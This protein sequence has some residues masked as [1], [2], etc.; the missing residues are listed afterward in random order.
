LPRCRHT[1]RAVRQNGHRTPT[2]SL[3][4]IIELVEASRRPSRTP[5]TP[6]PASPQTAIGSWVEGGGSPTRTRLGTWCLTL[7]ADRSELP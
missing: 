1:I 2:R 7:G 3:E 6:A 5:Q 4:R